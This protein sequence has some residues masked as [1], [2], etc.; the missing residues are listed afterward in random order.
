MATAQSI[1]REYLLSLGF[2]VNTQEQKK[3]DSAILTTNRSAVV[4]GISL[5]ALATTIG[6]LASRY[7]QAMEKMYYASR[8]GGG[9]VA[10]LQAMEFAGDKVGLAAGTMTA[11]VTTMA[12]KLRN[13]PGLIGL[14][15]KLG[16]ETKGRTP[17]Q[18]LLDLVDATKSM[19]YFKGASLAGLFGLDEGTY[20]VLRQNTA[21]IRA[22]IEER[23]KMDKTA[24]VDIEANAKAMADWGK[25]VTDLQAAFRTFEGVIATSLLGPM[26][27][28]TAVTKMLLEDWTKILNGPEKKTARQADKDLA[29]A[30]GFND[31]RGKVEQHGASGMGKAFDA[32]KR[33]LI[34]TVYGPGAADKRLGPS[35]YS[36]HSAAELAALDKD[37]KTGGSGGG[38]SDSG[39]NS[40]Q[41]MMAAADKLWGLTPGTMASLY[42]IESG[43]GTNLTSKTGVQGPFQ[44]TRPIQQRYAG[45]LDTSFEG[46]L[47][48][49][50]EY[51]SDLKKQFG[52]DAAAAAAWNGGQNA[53]RFG[54][55]A[56]VNPDE[57]KAFVPKFMAG[58]QQTNNITV[59]AGASANNVKIALDKA[60]GD[61]VRNVKT[62]VDGAN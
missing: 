19:P 43:N 45:K 15:Q 50:A 1:L 10:Q 8:K 31:G 28:V 55:G 12:S 46:Q 16:V 24:G 6:L 33:S 5:T 25:Q 61:L 54:P 7:Q 17:A 40:K 34:D 44:L 23:D 52:S 18:E 48:A 51:F 58:I 39:F 11:A 27:E 35:E 37:F 38:G 56:A 47:N 60:N 9:T 21:E 13:N 2:R 59:Q 41:E 20:Q 32:W 53:G 4:A 26:R 36:R 30:L 22:A 62:V 42:K 29:L 3:F 57:T 49:G 14:L